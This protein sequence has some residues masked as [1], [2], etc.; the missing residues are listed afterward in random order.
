MLSPQLE[1]LLRFI[2]SVPQYHTYPGRDDKSAEL[3][4]RCKKLEELGH[5]KIKSTEY[6]HAFQ[7]YIFVKA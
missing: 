4:E 5:V 6:Q 2:N 7:H 1:R 3:H